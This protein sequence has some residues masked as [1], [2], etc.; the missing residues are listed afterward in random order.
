M[1]FNEVI[2]GDQQEIFEA[3]GYSAYDVL[4]MPPMNIM[5]QA[6][7]AVDSE[8]DVL[9]EILFDNV[10]YGSFEN[11]KPDMMFIISAGTTIEDFLKPAYRG[12]ITK[13]ATST[14]LFIAEASIALDTSLYVT[15][16]EMYLPVQRLR[17]G[18]LIDGVLPFETLPPALKGLQSSYFA[19][20]DPLT[21]EASFLFSP[22]GQPMEADSSIDDMTGWHWE[23]S[24][25][26]T[27]TTGD[28]DSREIEVVLE[29][30]HYWVT[31]Y[32]TDSNNVTGSLIFDVFV[33]DRY[34]SNMISLGTNGA[35]ITSDWQNGVNA[36]ID[37]IGGAENILDRWRVTIVTFERWRAGDPELPN[38][39]F[40][41]HFQNDTSDTRA[42][43]YG[44]LKDR[45]FTIAGFSA[46]AGECKLS[47]LAITDTASPAAWDDISLP[48][49]ARVIAH[50][51]SRYSTL[52]RLC[53]VDFGDLNSDDWYGG[54]RDIESPYLLDACNQAADEINAAL[55]FCA[56]GQIGLRRNLNFVSDA[57]RDAADTIATITTSRITT[58]SFSR[59][60]V[61][62]LAQLQVG[63]RSYRT[64]NGSSLA[65]TATAP[66]IALGEGADFDEAP[67]QL[68]RANATTAEAR[69]EAGERAGNLLAYRDNSA[70]WTLELD[71]SYRFAQPS[72]H[73]WWNVIIPAADISNGVGLTADDRLLLKSFTH[74]FSP[75][76]G[77]R[78]TRGTFIQET[79]GGLT[80]ILVSVIPD[81]V[82]TAMQVRPPMSAYGGAFAPRSTIN[83][84]SSTPARKP[85]RGYAFVSMPGSPKQQQAAEEA[86]PRPGCVIQKP[87]INFRNPADV[88]TPFT[89]VNGELYDIYV[90]GSA[91]ISTTATITDDMTG[92]LGV[93]SHEVSATYPF[94][95]FSGG[96]ND[97][98]GT[99]SGHWAATDGRTGGG[100]IHATLE[101]GGGG[102]QGAVV[103]DLGAETIVTALDFWHR[104]NASPQFS[105]R[106]VQFYDAAKVLIGSPDQAFIANDFAFFTH[107]TWAGSVE[108]CRYVVIQI[109]GSNA[110]GAPVSAGFLD[111]ISVTFGAPDTRG[112]AFYQWQLDEDGNETEAE[113]YPAFRGLRLNSSPL[114]VIPDFD[115][116]HFYTIY[117]YEGIGSPLP[118]RFQM[119]DYTNV[120]NAQLKVLICTAGA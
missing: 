119:E 45:R 89:L 22:V 100:C 90:K 66:A 3:G 50:L 54:N 55:V 13:A 110:S 79:R 103:V 86:I 52:A 26:V 28:E 104:W 82:P 96:G 87:A 109:F 116:Q 5:M 88:V 7:P 59:E 105:I 70:E 71:G 114:A 40:V 68:L 112:D 29:E 118:L 75:E 62:N 10:A 81:N 9:F 2:S 91:K 37:Y 43:N 107:N 60:H 16:F 63:C 101:P 49:P 61:P 38:V 24:G 34:A 53:C 97:F 65:I 57:E 20:P 58:L 56:D 30:G 117:G 46:L 6:R 102:Y 115:S 32:C 21:G 92:G 83:S 113:L 77:T 25:A 94:G 23:F 47:F 76:R 15:V 4:C 42:D 69:A 78:V 39:V 36:S 31:V 8:A 74:T 80:M 98:T 67:N 84:T 120:E 33:Q 1:G 108:G 85:P 18:N 99:E 111:D 44:A 11:V 106:W 12:R 14:K 51:M 95:A 27:Y 72:V 41:G 19:E 48:N 64:A 93:H 17:S 35:E 73:Q